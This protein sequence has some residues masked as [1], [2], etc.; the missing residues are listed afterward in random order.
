MGNDGDTTRY[1][2]DIDDTG[3]GFGRR[4]AFAG[5]S[6]SFIIGIIWTLNSSTLGWML[7]GRC[8]MGTGVGLGLAYVRAVA[9]RH[10]GRV[11][12]QGAPDQGCQ[13]TL[14]LPAAR[15]D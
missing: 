1:R 9:E 5:A 15:G 13:V 14:S 4:G 12:A 3:D 11:R 8:I 2:L 7:V 6:L 10:G